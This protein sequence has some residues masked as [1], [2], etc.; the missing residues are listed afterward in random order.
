M[1]GVLLAG[2]RASRLEGGDKCLLELGRKKL[3]AWTIERLRP[4]VGALVL[5]ANGDPGRFA[6][7]GLPVIADYASPKIGDFAGPLAGVLAGMTYALAKTPEATGVLTAPTDTPFLPLNL[8]ARLV[9]ASAGKQLAVARSA[10]GIHPVVGLWPLAL[11]EDLRR[12]LEAGQRKVVD[13]VKAQGAVEVD[14]PE[15]RIGGRSFDPFFNINRPEDLAEAE[16]L[17]RGD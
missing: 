10:T 2:G 13:W 16:A 14:F 17:L 7:F 11:A 6:S 8:V 12:D 5:N 9:T 3:L 4:Q 15:E 1:I